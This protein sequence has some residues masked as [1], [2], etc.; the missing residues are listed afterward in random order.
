MKANLDVET[1]ARLAESWVEASVEG[2]QP[3]TIPGNLQYTRRRF[4]TYLDETLAILRDESGTPTVLA[5]EGPV[6]TPE[7]LLNV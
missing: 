3:V 2:L 1:G 6:V 5:R 4:V 7:V